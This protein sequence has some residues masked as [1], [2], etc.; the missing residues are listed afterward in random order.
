LDQIAFVHGGNGPFAVAGYRIGERALKEMKLP[1]GTFALEVIHKTP[2]EVQF[3]CIAD[4]VQAATG[5]SVGKLNLKLEEASADAVETIVRDR[6][7]GQTLVFRLKPDFVKRYWNLP[8]DKLAAAGKE[9]LSL[10]DDEIF[11]IN[12]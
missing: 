11:S 6:K 7:S 5:V 10:P 8:H 2:K 4:G 1:R 9:V 3:S 12:P